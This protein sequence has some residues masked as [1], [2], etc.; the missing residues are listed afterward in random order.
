MARIRTIKPEFPQ[1]ESMGRVS[2]D[3]RLLFILLWTLCDDS[4]RTRA[5]SRMLASLLFPY[6]DDAPG[7]VDG[8]LT[9]LE[10]V[11]CV[12]RYAVDGQTYVQVRKWAEHQRIDRPSPSKFPEF[13]ESSRVIA[14]AR[15]PSALDQGPRKGSRTKDIVPPAEGPGPKYPEAFEKFWKAYPRTDN[16]SK[17]D[18]LK[19]WKQ[20]A[21]DLPPIDD[22]LR[23]V[24]GY[25]AFVA[26]ESARKSGYTVKHAQGWLSGKRWEAYLEPAPLLSAV[27]QRDWAD[28]IPAW[29]GF[30][31]TIPATVWTNFFAV[32][33]L[34][35]GPPAVLQAPSA[36][37]RDR[38]DAQH[39][40][41]LRAIFGPEFEVM[42]KL[43]A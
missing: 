36:F 41:A 11:G 29:A 17:A 35:P 32:C 22:L 30:K 3:A 26:K 25:R 20:V 6:D 9:E 5:A 1:S 24:A 15:E 34:E 38:I 2:R 33:Q 37:V 42:L 8:W 27:S 28:E 10:M 23:A 18:A 14:H 16:M 13:D 21:R 39:G 40:S 12:V 7:L 43:A 4:G 19:A 31:K